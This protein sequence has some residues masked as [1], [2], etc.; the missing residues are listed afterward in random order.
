MGMTPQSL[1]QGPGR[2]SEVRANNQGVFWIQQRPQEKG[3]CV[4]MHWKDEGPALCISPEGVS[5]GTK[6]NGYG[7]GSTLLTADQCF[8]SDQTHDR[9]LPF[10]QAEESSLGDPTEAQG[11]FVFVRE[12]EAG[13]SLVEV[14]ASGQISQVLHESHDFYAAPR[15]DPE[16]G[17]LAFIAWDLPKMP[18]DGTRLYGG[19]SPREGAYF[20]QPTWHAGQLYFLSD[21]TDFGQL[22]VNQDGEA[23]PVCK[24]WPAKAD[25]ALPLWNLGMQTFLPLGEDCF[26]IIYSLE[27]WYRLGIIERGFL[28]ELDLPFCAFGDQL[29]VWKDQLAFSAATSTE[30]FAVRLLDWKSG[31]YRTISELPA[32]ISP[33][34]RISCA[35]PLT[36]STSEGEV[37]HAFFYRPTEPH[38]PL[39]LMSHGGPTSY[40]HAGYSA[41]IQFWV[42]QGFAVLD[43]NYRGSTGFGRP[44]WQALKHAWGDA[45]AKDCIAAA[46]YVVQQGWV[47]PKN[48][49][50][51]GSS[52]G[53]FLSLSAMASTDIFKAGAIYYGVSDLDAFM[54]HTHRFESGYNDWLVGKAVP[55]PV[56][57][58]AT[59]NR[60]IIFFHGLKDK[61][62]PLSHSEVL[63]K[64][65]RDKGVPTALHTYPEEGHSFRAA[66]TIADSLEKELAFYRQFME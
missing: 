28:R 24:N 3:R 64:A 44:Y 56:Q 48:L 45:D 51:R 32:A 22:Y 41:K 13:Q 12:T 19:A 7:G 23:N 4:L 54:T 18:W 61:V 29:A 5:V 49:F 40:T 15:L 2:I 42:Q 34:E 31:R 63:Y 66:E 65:L 21:K 35:E 47:D 57:R 26:A 46:D 36:F 50:I 11:R 14:S 38:P 30:P 58:V 55:S 6:I 60:P 17:A 25:A 37:A 10:P 43:V 33:P 1:A 39:L 20:S 62:V 52:A 59:L 16:T 27:G 8:Y 53:G 9:W